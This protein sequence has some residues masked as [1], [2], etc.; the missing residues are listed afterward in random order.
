MYRDILWTF[1]GIR[2]PR[3]AQNHGHQS[4]AQAMDILANAVMVGDQLQDRSRSSPYQAVDA[5]H[6]RW[7]SLEKGGPP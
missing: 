1:G 4:P 3:K 7:S 5:V 2:A 6:G